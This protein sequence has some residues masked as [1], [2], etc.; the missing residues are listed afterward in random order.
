MEKNNLKKLSELE[1]RKEYRI[2]LSKKF[3]ALKNLSGSEDV[4]RAWVNI[5]RSIKT[6]AKESLCLYKLK[7]HQP[8][9]GEKCL[10][11]LD[12]RQQIKMQWFRIQKNKM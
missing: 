4:N 2:K 7:Q 10:C 12:Q 3:A 8:W 1:V 11:F 9:F 6:S 5:K